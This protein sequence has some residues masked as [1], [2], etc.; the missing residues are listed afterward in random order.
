MTVTV[1]EFR[2]ILNEIDGRMPKKFPARKRIM[3]FEEY[4]K[5]KT[6][7]VGEESKKEKTNETK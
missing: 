6:R 3:T 5:A 2:A 1:D 4:H 7:V